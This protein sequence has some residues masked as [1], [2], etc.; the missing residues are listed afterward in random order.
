MA[1]YQRAVERVASMKV[2]PSHFW[3]S[4]TAGQAALGYLGILVS[5]LSGSEH[6]MAMEGIQKSIDRD[7]DAQKANIGNAQH[8]AAGYHNL[9]EMNLGIFKNADTARLAT[10]AMLKDQLGAQAAAIEARNLG[11]MAQAQ[12]M[13]K[14]GA[15]AQSA[16]I[17][18]QKAQEGAYALDLSA[19]Q[20]KQQ[21]AYQT[22]LQHVYG[23]TPSPRNGQPAP[24]ASKLSPDDVSALIQ[25]SKSENVIPTAE[26]RVFVQNAPTTDQRQAFPVNAAARQD[27]DE[28][29]GIARLGL[30]GKLSPEQ[31]GRAKAVILGFRSKYGKATG[32]DFN[33]SSRTAEIWDDAMGD[34]SQ[35][36]SKEAWLHAPAEIEAYDRD[37]K[38]SNDDVIESLVRLFTLHR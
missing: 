35:L 11:P 15:L 14:A 8:A 16:Q 32:V 12:G 13:T 20:R 17:D 28:L 34:P 38:R 18:R 9:F 19:R 6:N 3:G 21:I 1:D 23:S 30:A 5:G 24:G 22:A 26:G 33:H 10:A 2:D 37:L 36:L 27:L 29:R 7:I 4:R 31:A 25:G